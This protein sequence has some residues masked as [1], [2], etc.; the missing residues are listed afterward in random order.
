MPDPTQPSP[1]PAAGEA[2]HDAYEAHYELL[3]YIAVQKF[4]VPDADVRPLIHDIF[5]AYMRNRAR[6]QKPRAWLVGAAFNSCRLYWRERGRED[7]MCHGSSETCD[8]AAAADDVAARVDLGTVLRRLPRQCREV[9]H[10]RFFEEYS[11]EEIA[12]HFATTVGYARKMVHRCV[13]SARELFTR[14]ARVR[15]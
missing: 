1:L 8:V 2:T 7:E 13:L 11:S 3:E 9:L 15:R 14:M 4:H 5:V 12:R 10:L 6:I